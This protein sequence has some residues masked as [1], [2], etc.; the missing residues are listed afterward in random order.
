M[1]PTTRRTMLK[2]LAAVAAGGYVAPKVLSIPQA[3]AHHAPGHTGTSPFP[4]PGQGRGLDRI[5]TAPGPPT[6]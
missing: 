6:R 5:P 3:S 2:R 1:N 4:F